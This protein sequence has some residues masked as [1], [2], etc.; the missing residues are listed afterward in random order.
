[1]PCARAE[2]PILATVSL[3]RHDVRLAGDASKISTFLS[4]SWLRPTKGGPLACGC[5]RV[6]CARFRRHWTGRAALCLLPKISAPTRRC[7]APSFAGWK[8]ATHTQ[9]LAMP[10]AQSQRQSPHK[11]GRRCRRAYKYSRTICTM[12]NK[13]SSSK[14]Y[15]NCLI[16]APKIQSG[17]ANRRD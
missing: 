13:I 7:P 12:L 8:W 11:M 9:A 10:K 15:D 1:M 17:K 5:R 2:S 16:L 14:C 3:M 6:P 4:P